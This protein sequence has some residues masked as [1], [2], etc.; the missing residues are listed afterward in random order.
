MNGHIL[1]QL[2]FL[3]QGQYTSIIIPNKYNSSGA[4]PNIRDNILVL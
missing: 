4:R 2:Y 3:E 1:R